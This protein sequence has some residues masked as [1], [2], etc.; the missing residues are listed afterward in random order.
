MRFVEETNRLILKVENEDKA[1][2]VLRFYQRNASFFTPFEPNV[3][4]GFYT[5][6]YQQRFLAYEMRDTLNGSTLRYFL[7][8][9]EDP[10]TIIGC[11]NLCNILHGAF[12]KASLGY[13]LD[14]AYTGNGYATEAVLKL[15]QIAAVDMKL[16]RIEAKVV[17]ENLPSIHLLN[18]LHFQ[19]E[20]VEFQSILVNNI[21][22]DLQRYSLILY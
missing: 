18:R 21:W 6:S 14:Y 22:R 20:G 1:S 8:L 4:E 3:S 7:Y 16:H 9:K 17:P 13:K 12:S 15:L 5:E 10:N 2:E 11:V 19:Y